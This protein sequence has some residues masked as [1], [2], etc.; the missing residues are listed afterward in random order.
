V[1]RDGLDAL[2]V[3]GVDSCE[4]VCALAAGPRDADRT[5]PVPLDSAYAPAD[6]LNR[7][8]SRI[9]PKRRIGPNV[10]GLTDADQR[11]LQT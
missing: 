10:F 4:V 3:V 1:Q 2:E 5:I 6:A 7:P 8:C 9:P 11:E